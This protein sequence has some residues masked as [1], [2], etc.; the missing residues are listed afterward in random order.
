MAF[1]KKDRQKIIDE[2]LSASGANMFVPAEFIDWLGAKPDHEAYELFY[3]ID[4]ATA[5]REHRILLARQ[6]ANGLRIVAPV[7]TAPASAS[8]VSVAVRE[9]PAMVSPMAGRKEGGG[10]LAFDPQDPVVTAELR[11]Q[12]ATALRGWL[13]RY[14]GVM[15]LG[16]INV[17]PIE[18]IVVRIEGD[19][20]SAA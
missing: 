2:Y 9:F 10:Y 7:S 17:S 13:N 5:A 19:V 8:V 16:G 11:R 1:T 15:E 3:G 20:A 12:G 14:R 18:E 4:D 6:M